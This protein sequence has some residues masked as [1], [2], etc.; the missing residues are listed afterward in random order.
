M[1]KK[2]ITISLLL[3]IL[4]A[5]FQY[6]VQINY[7]I[8]YFKNINPS[9]D[10][11]TYELGHYIYFNFIKNNNI[12]DSIL[13][14]I[15]GQWYWSQRFSVLISNFFL[16]KETYS[17]NFINYLSFLIANFVIFYFLNN[18]NQSLKTNFLLS[19]LIWIF[20]I[21]YHF[22]YYGSLLN[23]G[24]DSIF[25]A[26]L[27]CLIFS[28]FLLI[29]NIT[30]KTNQI[31]FILSFIFCLSSRGNSLPIL[32]TV[33]LIPGIIL[34]IRL[35]YKKIKLEDL[36]FIICLPLIFSFYFYYKNINNIFSYYG[37]FNFIKNPYFFEYFLI[38]LRN[39]PGIFFYYPHSFEVDLMKQ[40]NL[41]T[42]VISMFFHFIFLV[43][44]F[45]IKKLKD[46]NFK[47]YLSTSVFIYF[48]FLIYASTF[49]N[50]PHI[51]I[52]NALFIWSPMMLAIT[53]LSII[54]LKIFFEKIN[55]KLIFLLFFSL[56]IYLPI[57]SMKYNLNKD[58]KYYEGSKPYEVKDLADFIHDNKDLKPIILYT[59]PNWISNRL[60]DF[61]LMQA[62]KKPINWFRDKYAD[63]IWNP[64]RTG[65]IYKNE[66]R[67]EIRN[68]FQKS[69]LIVIP[70]SSFGYTKQDKNNLI[71]HGFYRYNNLITEYLKTDDLNKFEIVKKFNT[72]KTTLLVLK[73]NPKTTNKI[74]LK[75]EN[76][77][78]YID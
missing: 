33:S 69:N 8:E 57:L 6:I 77:I 53:I 21:N 23:S 65:E 11:Y 4:Y 67:S 43:S 5:L 68:I 32:L 64:T 47:I 72:K 10:S 28:L 7:S 73:R 49:W 3:L 29:N 30:K 17:F 37:D 22:F 42:F 58:I 45:Y 12:L 31:I 78:Y 44:I 52:Y 19:L 41:Y 46:N 54:Y 48:F 39:I 18:I 40:F 56:I 76:D 1:L 35:Y 75:F 51:N 2:K 26:Y 9:G 71:L 74:K 24:L 13:Y 36:I 63:D 61:Y 62:N 20:P 66:I 27:Y 60:V 34:L 59:E 25:I 14:L 38:F 15:N 16:V 50:T 70:Q 55:S